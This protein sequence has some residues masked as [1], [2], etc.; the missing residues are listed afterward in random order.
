VEEVSL[1]GFADYKRR[2]V[3][4]INLIIDPQMVQL[5][6]F[7]S[8]SHK[9]AF[10]HE[11]TDMQPFV[12][13][14]SG[15]DML[16]EL[17]MEAS[18]S[19]ETDRRR[20]KFCIQQATELLQAKQSRQERRQVEFSIVRGGL[21]HWQARRVAAY[22]ES[23][24][25]SKISVIELAALVHLSIGHFCRAFKVSFGTSPLAYVM[26]QRML[27]AQAI[28]AS[29]EAPL[30][31]IA[32]DCGMCDQA[33]FSHTFRRIIGVSPNVW[34]RQIS[35]R[36]RTEASSNPQPSPPKSAAAIDPQ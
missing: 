18:A 24:I 14:G 35:A 7:H 30:S 13:R 29:S 25:C 28:M 21:A 6:V 8:R 10:F 36:R 19:I 23:N 5:R 4:R 22:I 9:P 11:A 34:R 3:G 1:D 12:S 33:H 2:R 16:G 31:R 26:R 15:H 32:L 27:R 20:A 17:L